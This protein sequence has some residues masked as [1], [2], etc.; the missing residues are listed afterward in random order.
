MLVGYTEGTTWRFEVVEH[1]D[2]YLVQSRDL[3]TS[4]L[5]GSEQRLFRTTVAALAFA[6][7]SAVLDRAAAARIEGGPAHTLAAEIHVRNAAFRDISER[8][9][10]DGCEAELLLAWQHHERSEN[11]RLH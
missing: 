9:L 5:D 7:L 8:L 6:N 4:A 3:V 11:Y 10:D 2:G 1:P